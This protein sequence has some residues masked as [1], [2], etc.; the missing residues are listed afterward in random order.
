VLCTADFL[1]FELLLPDGYYRV[2]RIADLLLSE[3]A[4]GDFQPDGSYG[5]PCTADFLIW[6][7]G[8]HRGRPRPAFSASGGLRLPP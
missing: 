5:V 7:L 1:L 4:S 8:L 2:L 6:G 3:P